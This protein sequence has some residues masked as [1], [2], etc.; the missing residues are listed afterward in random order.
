MPWCPMK[1]R[2][3]LA[4]MIVGTSTLA[5]PKLSSLET[6]ALETLESRRPGRDACATHFAGDAVE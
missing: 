5:C 4:Q 1:M 3:A 6:L 2:K